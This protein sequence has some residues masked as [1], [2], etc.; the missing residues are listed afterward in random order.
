M[1]VK[2]HKRSA[3]A[4]KHVLQNLKR[5]VQ[6]GF[7]DSAAVKGIQELSFVVTHL[8]LA[9]GICCNSAMAQEF[10]HGAIHL[11]RAAPTSVGQLATVWWGQRTVDSDGRGG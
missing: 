7:V 4:V 6:V 10:K 8:A 2:R 1:G 9:A 11:D 3:A 5:P